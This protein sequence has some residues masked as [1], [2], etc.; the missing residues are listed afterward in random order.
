MFIEYNNHGTSTAVYP[1][2]KSFDKITRKSALEI[3]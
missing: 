1:T 2:M 3:I